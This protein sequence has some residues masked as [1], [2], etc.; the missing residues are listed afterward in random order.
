MKR[1]AALLLAAVMSVGTAF[2]V[3][4]AET[5]TDINDVPWGGAQAYINNVYANGLMVGDLNER[6]E[7]VF[8]AKESISYNE[9][10]QLMYTLSGE[11][12]DDETLNKWAEAMRSNNI[13][14]WAYESVAYG[15][16]NGI[17]TRTDIA[18]FMNLDG[19]ARSA[20]REDTAYIFGR[21]LAKK[22]FESKAGTPDFA[23]KNKISAVCQQ[24][25]TLLSGLDV[26]VGDENNNFN[27]NNTINRAEMAV[28]ATKV[29]TLLKDISESP[30]HEEKSKAD[31]SGY[32]NNVTD[33]SLMLYTFD[34]KSVILDRAHNSQYYLDGEEIS[35]R[36]IYSLTT[37]G[38]LVKA[39]V[40]VNS[41]NVAMEIYCTR[42]DVEGQV[43]GLGFKS[44]EYKKGSKKIPYA[45][46]T[47]TITYAN[48]LSRSYRL[49]EDT[50][51]YYDDEEIDIEDFQELL[52]K[53]LP[54]VDPDDEVV[55]ECVSDGSF[56]LLDRWE[57]DDDDDEK[58]LNVYAL[59][60]VEVND[61]Y[62][63][64]PQVRLKELRMHTVQLEEAVI[65]AINNERIIVLDGEG[66]EYEYKIAD[67]ARF[68]VDGDKERIT[69][70]KK[71]VKLNLSTVEIKYDNDGY[72]TTLKAETK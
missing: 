31:Y 66:R 56:D 69:D 35:T 20:S 32:I 41:S 48:G 11:K 37:N 12:T 23:D 7:R 54:D 45:F 42:A 34:G 64:Y 46:Y 61:E 19:S 18:A 29:N 52:W 26:I 3:S 25:V 71:A 5:F 24:Y 40:Y 21:F 9:T 49:D 22:G 58:Y 44:G 1:Q 53:S 14:R 60:D 27:P 39:D 10:V 50:D 4:A 36:G 55:A 8:R 65:S 16:E 51:F 72:V 57:P 59:A 28:I 70:F 6:G 68:Y 13:P 38:I 47:V 63:V 67:K 2:G 33:T 15:L 17:I 30:V 62:Y 43:T